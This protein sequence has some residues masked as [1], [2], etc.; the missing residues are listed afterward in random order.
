M[1]LYTIDGPSREARGTHRRPCYDDI[2]RQLNSLPF[3]VR[4]A[5]HA[6]RGLPRRVHW[7]PHFR[8]T[9]YRPLLSLGWHLPSHNS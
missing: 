7:A 6:G 4:D 3:T 8:F 2:G 9:F 1:V 5:G